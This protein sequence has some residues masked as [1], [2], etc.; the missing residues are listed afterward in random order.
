MPD[1]KVVCTDRRLD[2]GTVILS[3]QERTLHPQTRL[4]ARN[5]RHTGTMTNDYQPD[6]FDAHENDD[7]DDIDPLDRPISD[8]TDDELNSLLYKHYPNLMAE[9]AETT[10]KAYSPIDAEFLKSISR[11]NIPNLGFDYSSLFEDMVPKIDLSAYAPKIELPPIS[12]ELQKPSTRR[13]RASPKASPSCQAWKPSF[14]ARESFRSSTQDCFPSPGGN[15][16]RIS[17]A[18]TTSSSPSTPVSYSPRPELKT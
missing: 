11:A 14:K 17:R 18:S 10:R 9:I 12:D 7:H 5:P 15:P 1:A 4:L 2:S 16:C 13:T 3:R 8:F 6:D